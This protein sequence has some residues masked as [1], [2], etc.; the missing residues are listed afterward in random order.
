MLE[1]LNRQLLSSD[2]P[3]RDMSVELC[4]TV[5]L[6]LTHLLPHL[7]CLM[8]SLAV[9]LRITP[10]LA[11]QG[12]RTLKLC[13]DSLTWIL[14]SASSSANS[15]RRSSTTSNWLLSHHLAHTT[16]RILWKLGGRNCR[17]LFKEPALTWHH[18]SEPAKMATS[19]HGNTES[20]RLSPIAKLAV[21]QLPRLG[22]GDQI[23]AYNYLE[24]CVSLFS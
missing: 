23:H 24:I 20:V 7:S 6:R 12:L 13:I 16:I 21:R 3:T 10:N 17:L 14:R 5:P 4:L 11:S 1:S 22:A 2:G 15:R 9:A 18:S 19:F 8:R